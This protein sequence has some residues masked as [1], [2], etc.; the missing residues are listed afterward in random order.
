MR[1]FLK[2]DLESLI[3]SGVFNEMVV[4]D[5]ERLDRNVTM[6]VF[7]YEDRFYETCYGNPSDYGY[8]PNCGVE[9]PCEEVFPE[10]V[11]KRK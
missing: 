11:Y 2:T 9:V 1:N 5:L 3:N 10:I 6:M 8:F 4:M 7:R